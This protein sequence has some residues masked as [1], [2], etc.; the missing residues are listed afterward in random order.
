VFRNQTTGKKGFALSGLTAHS[1]NDPVE[2]P[3]TPPGLL[4]FLSRLRHG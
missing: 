1:P 2:A 4:L 3:A